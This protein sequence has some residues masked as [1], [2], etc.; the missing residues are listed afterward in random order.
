MQKYVED[1]RILLLHQRVKPVLGFRL[2]LELFV[3]PPDNKRRDL[4][5]LCK[6]TLDALQYA[7]IFADDFHIQQLYI[8]RREIRK[9][10][11]IEFVLELIN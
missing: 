1:V 3:Y 11:E 7:G 8:E 5:N 4:D 9:H 10:G 2:R 6:A